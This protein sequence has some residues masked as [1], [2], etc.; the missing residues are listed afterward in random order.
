VQARRHGVSLRATARALDRPVA[1][2]NAH[3]RRRRPRQLLYRDCKLGWATRPSVCFQRSQ[4]RTAAVTP[5]GREVDDSSLTPNAQSRASISPRPSLPV[6]TLHP[7]APE[8]TRLSCPLRRL[9]LA[10]GPLSGPLAAHEAARGQQVKRRELFIYSAGYRSRNTRHARSSKTKRSR[11]LW[12]V[13]QGTNARHLHQDFR[14]LSNFA[15]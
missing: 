12:S 14:H 9:G 15:A 3:Y 4:R 1:P 5:R 10:P 13:N 8:S 6:Y 2:P 7:T 11:P